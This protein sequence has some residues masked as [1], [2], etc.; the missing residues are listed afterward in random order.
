MRISRK[1]ETGWWLVPTCVVER[2][3]KGPG[4]SWAHFLERGDEQVMARPPRNSIPGPWPGSSRSARGGGIWA[5]TG[6][7]TLRPVKSPAGLV[8][9]SRTG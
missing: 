2:A 4:S 1:G 9:R 3:L 6:P 7:L 8:C 5:S